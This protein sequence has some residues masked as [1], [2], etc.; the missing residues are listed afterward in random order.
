[1]TIEYVD[2][3]ERRDTLWRGPVVLVVA[4]GAISVIGALLGVR[5]AQVVQSFAVV[6]LSIVLEA[7]PFIVLG[8]IV[9][10]ALETWGSERLAAFLGRLHGVI[11]LRR[12]PRC[13]LP[14]L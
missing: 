13:L 3:V 4:A 14:D 5:Q 11:A 9:G 2:V 12:P 1:V 6:F 10:A 8:S 7:L